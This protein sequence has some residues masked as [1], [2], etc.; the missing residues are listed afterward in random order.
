MSVDAVTRQEMYLQ[1]LAGDTAITLPEPVTRIE[2]YWLDIAKRIESGIGPG[3]GITVDSALSET[4]TNPVQN[5]VVSKRFGELSEQ[6][7]DKT[8]ITLDVGSDGLVYIF[9]N[10]VPVG[11]G[12]EL[13]TVIDSDALPDY[14]K[15]YLVSKA[16]EINTTYNAVS[17]N[18]SSFFWYTDAHW[19]TNYGTS[20]AILKY[21]SKN[22]GINK[23]FFGGDIAVDKSGEIELMTAWRE[24]VANIPNHHSVVGNH[25]NQV[26]EFP[27]AIERGNF[28]LERT[29]DMV[30]GTD[31]TNGNN[32]YY[33]DNHLENTRY[34]C[35]STGRMWTLAD[36]L[37]WCIEVLNSTPQGWHIVIISHIWL[38][39]DYSNG[40]GII[41]TPERYTQVYLDLFDAYNLR[42]SGTTEMHSKSYDFSSS[43]AKVEF[44]IGGHV[45][46]DYDFK[47]N[48]GI[49][50]IL[51]ECDGW[52]ERDDV[53]VATQGTTTENC[54]YAIIAD[55]DTKVIR[56]INVGR[57]DTRSVAIISEVGTPDEEETGN[58]TNWVKV[59][60]ADNTETTIYNDGKGYKENYRLSNG[61]EVAYEGRDITGYIKAKA[62]DVIRFKNVTFKEG[63][64]IYC[65]RFRDTLEFHSSTGFDTSDNFSTWSPIF[66]DDGNVKELTVP[67]AISS[68]CVYFRFCV[69]DINE[70]SIITVNELID[71]V[72]S[73]NPSTNYINL[74]PTAVG[75]DGQTLDANNDGI[76]DGYKE[77]VRLST[78]S[79]AYSS[80][81]GF[82]CTG[83]IP[84]KQGDTFYL[85]NISMYHDEA[86]TNLRVQVSYRA[87]NYSRILETK[88]D[89]ILNGTID[90]EV[91][92]NGNVARFTI[93]EWSSIDAI[94]YII[95]CANDINENS[96]I[97]KNEPID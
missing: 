59:A 17:G 64:H 32:Y 24:L 92:E 54:V 41:T 23:T 43:K 6:K 95:I 52:G 67:S 88:I 34:I 44:A 48:E 69:Q 4:S 56:I 94:E 73:D 96:I 50:V 90:S 36:E 18:K 27:T 21:L 80:G 66:Y 29:G 31:E 58:Y 82:D 3:G 76:A 47:T 97:T 1:Y 37:E 39:Y 83:L 10:G 20:P 84:A 22:T 93:P 16:S 15:D 61:E 28:F 30:F 86:D 12:V 81:T 75:F 68:S 60:Y 46:Q 91:D 78:S 33:I 45:H 87:E 14:W 55:Y 8:G 79:N 62:G 70:N 19:K 63:W 89:A 38:N 2:K 57:G 25:D 11:N 7:V 77:G 5:K 85:K 71:D 74:L 72:V 65:C 35:L 9:I 42:K 49:P 26:T 40:T 13:G 51:T 53:S